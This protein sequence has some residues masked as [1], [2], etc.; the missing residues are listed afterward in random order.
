MFKSE[1]GIEYVGASQWCQ[2]MT[3]GKQKTNRNTNKSGQK[4]TLPW[5]SPCVH[6]MN[7]LVESL[8]RYYHNVLH[9]TA[10]KLY[11]A[12]LPACLHHEFI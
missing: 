7:G 3:S 8:Q 5:T 4:G 2:Y 9:A 1:L 12:C 6:R 11:G 10:A